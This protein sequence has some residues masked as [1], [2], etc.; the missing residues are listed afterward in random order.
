MAAGRAQS[1]TV[2]RGGY[3]IFYERVSENLTM[4]AVR[5]N[6]VN[7][8]QFTVLNPISFR[9]FPHPIS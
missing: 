1:K 8:Q 6:G 7:Q 4:T 9:L 2:L 5:L 3:G